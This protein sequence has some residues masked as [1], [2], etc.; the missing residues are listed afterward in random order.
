LNPLVVT[1]N[2]AAT[3]PA[4]QALVRAV[5]FH[6]VNSQPSV[7]DRVATVTLTRAGG[8]SSVN[9]IIK[10]GLVR[11]T[12]FQE[13]ADHGYGTY[14]GA[15]DVELW[16]TFPDTG[17][18][19]GST[20]DGLGIGMSGLIPDRSVLLRFDNIIGDRPGQI[21]TNAI[22]VAAELELYVKNTGDGSPLHRMLVPW[23]ANMTY[24]ASG[25]GYKPDDSRA[26]LAFDSQFGVV[27]LSGATG[28]GLKAFSVA[29]D[30]QAW[31]NGETNHGWVMPAWQVTG[32]DFTAFAPSE[33]TNI[34]ER[35]SLRVLW[36]PTG[37]SVANFRYGVNGYTNAVDTRV[38]GGASADVEFST[39]N[40]MFPDYE[41]TSEALDEEHVLLRFDDIVG[42]GP[43]Q[44]PL[45]AT[46][47]AAM[48]DLAALFGNSPGHGGHFHA[49]LKPWEATNTWNALVNGIQADGLEAAVAISAAAGDP[50]LAMVPGGYFSFDMTTDVQAWAYNSRP[51]YG[52]AFLPWEFGRDGFGIGSAEQT[53]E[54]SRPQLRVFYS[55]G[56]IPQTDLI[57]LQAPLWS[58]TSVQVKFTGSANKTYSV[59]RVGTL[60]G[61]WEARGPATTGA[62]GKATFTDNAPLAGA[63]FYRVVY[64][65]GA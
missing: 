23:D 39:V 29:P 48:L 65:P 22:I 1:L 40:I 30:V 19:E 31:A 7:A 12:Q 5:M 9:K 21:P 4:A 26:R 52:W 3:P 56:M 27:D 51:N 53:E 41:V 35:P 59:Q 46:I 63:A 13:G 33:A 32:Y 49:M 62:D 18:P 14:T 15:A 10:L 42:P 16:A 38:R 28:A 60:G 11:I 55:P 8:V 45:G 20:A 47:H 6:N 34:V 24:S 37:T 44:V 57:M 61:I 36:V 17:Y 2:S 25:D 58:P 54:R 64:I 50:S 43:N